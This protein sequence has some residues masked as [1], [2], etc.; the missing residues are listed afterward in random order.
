MS[1]TLELSQYV[2]III[3]Q[4]LS[5]QHFFSLLLLPSQCTGHVVQTNLP[6]KRFDLHFLNEVYFHMGYVELMTSGSSH[7]KKQT[8]FRKC[9]LHQYWEGLYE[10]YVLYN[11]PS[12]FLIREHTCYIRSKNTIW[13][14]FVYNFFSYY[15]ICDADCPP[16]FLPY[17]SI[18]IHHTD[19]F[20]KLPFFTSKV[21]FIKK[22]CTIYN[23]SFLIYFLLLY[24]IMYLC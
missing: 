6:Q 9:R 22:G 5:E 15:V 23:Y 14:I 4:F 19:C 8:S 13:N 21:I 12:Q 3:S 10:L 18:L 20:R 2:V 1:R 11:V 7:F 24:E 17:V 16:Y